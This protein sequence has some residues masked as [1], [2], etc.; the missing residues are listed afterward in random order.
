MAK[1]T[2]AARCCAG[3]AAILALAGGAQ[4]QSPCAPRFIIQPGDT[5]HAVG[6]ECRVSVDALLAANPSIGVADAVAV[7]T[8]PTI[9]G[10]TGGTGTAEAGERYEVRSGDTLHSL[11]VRFGTTVAR[12]RSANPGVEAEDLAV[13]ATLTIPRGGAG[14][15]GPRD[16]GRTIRVEPQG[17][18]PRLPVAIRGPGDTPGAT[19]TI[20]S[21]EGRLSAGSECPIITTAEGIRYSLAGDLGPYGSGE[22]VQIEGEVA[23]MSFCME[24]EATLAVESVEPVAGD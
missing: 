6:E 12:L 16:G 5:L 8:E 7:G 21:V 2:G 4:A 13:G 19:V 17:V 15:A 22:A 9:P 24:G 3:A 20:G 14:R 10:A 1:T 18:A 23:E 11:A